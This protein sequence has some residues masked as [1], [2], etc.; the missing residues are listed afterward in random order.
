M[1]KLVILTIVLLLLAVNFSL[2]LAAPWNNP[3]GWWLE[4]V[5][6][7]DDTFD[8]WVINDYSVASFDENGGVGITKSLYIYNNELDE[9][10]QLWQVPGKGVFKKTQWCTW[11]LDGILFGG[12]ILVP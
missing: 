8:V 1:K 10:V 12:D 3:N 2:V 6:C 11:E 7:G 9:F 4:D 5:T